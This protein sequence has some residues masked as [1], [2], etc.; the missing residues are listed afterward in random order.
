M[1]YFNIEDFI[2]NRKSIR[3]FKSDLISRDIIKKILDAAIWAPSA[4][5]TQPWEINVVTGDALNNIK[6][7]NLKKL[8]QGTKQ[9]THNNFEG[10]FRERQII[11]AKQ[12]FTLM[13]IKREDKEKNAEW[14]KRGFCFFD[15]PAVIIISID[16]S[17]KDKQWS[18]FDIGLITQN[19]CLL[20]L[21]YDLGTCIDAQGICFP[22]VIREHA[23]IPG[24]KEIIIGIAIG[25]PDWDFPA[26]S[27]RSQREKLENIVSWT[28]WKNNY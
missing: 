16:N 22:E 5:N 26:N 28:G 7:D 1:E 13:D 20:A 19:I 4:I 9:S 21:Y 6:R 18:L 23:R 8:A 27:L 12:I 2:R 14:T 25:Y 17:L 11:L 10:I 3:G 15:A 24:N